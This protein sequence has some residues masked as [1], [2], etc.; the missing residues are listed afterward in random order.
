[1]ASQRMQGVQDPIIPHIGS[2]IRSHPGTISLGQGVVHYPPPERT[3]HYADR[4]WADPKNHLYAPVDGIAS[5]KSAIV[6]KL[7]KDNDIHVSDQHCVV[8]TAGGNMAF[9]NALFAITEPEDEVILLA[10]FYFNHDMAIAMLGCKTV[11][12][13]VDE[14][15][16]IDF[17]TLQSAITP[18][19]KAIVTNSPNNP[20]G[21]VYPAESLTAVNKL[22]AAHNIYH[23]NDEAYEYFT[24]DEIAHFS[25]GSLPDSTAHTISLFSLSKSFGFAGWRIGYMAAPAHLQLALMKAQDTNLI[26]ATVVSQHAALGA[27]EAGMAYPKSFMKGLTDVRTMVLEQLESIAD[28]CTAPQTAGAFY[29]FLKVNTDMSSLVLAERLIQEFK[30]A[31]IPGSAFGMSDGCYLRIAFGALQKDTVEEGI[32]RLIRGLRELIV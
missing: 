28:I 8:V 17:E 9:L 13:H 30:V 14:S 19:T 15:Y 29:V 27:F 7:A 12:V 26:N 10:P 32:G 6:D 1:M 4:F 16:Q 18:R 23:I 3:R 5:L 31:V 21:A 22:C 25:P 20:T 11:M 24:Y 2:L